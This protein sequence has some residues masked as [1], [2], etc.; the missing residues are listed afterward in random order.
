MRCQLLRLGDICLLGS[1]QTVS[2]F[3]FVLVLCFEVRGCTFSRPNDDKAAIGMLLR[4]PF[5]PS[6]AL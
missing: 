3:F 5:K 2:W 1:I 6:Q 4:V